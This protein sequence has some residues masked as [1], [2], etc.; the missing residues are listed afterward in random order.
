[1]KKGKFK[2]VSEEKFFIEFLHL[3]YYQHSTISSEIF[4]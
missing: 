3:I 4:Y 2:N 1:M